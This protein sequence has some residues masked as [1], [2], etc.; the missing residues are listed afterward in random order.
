[1]QETCC[2]W[3]ARGFRM[4]AA[5]RAPS[6][7]RTTLRASSTWRRSTT[8]PDMDEMYFP[9]GQPVQDE[10]PRRLLDELWRY[11]ERSKRAAYGER[12]VGF[13]PLLERVRQLPAKDWSASEKLYARDHQR[14]RLPAGTE[15]DW[16]ERAR[17]RRHAA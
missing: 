14:R 6:S 16:M 13:E 9:P 17:A 1:M 11:D 5:G 10:D 4:P 12:Y 8:G 3:R 7:M 2:G 15:V